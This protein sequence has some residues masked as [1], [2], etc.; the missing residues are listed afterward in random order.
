[1]LVQ[2]KLKQGTVRTV[3]WIPHSRKVRKGAL[4]IL[5]DGDESA[6]EVES[7]GAISEEAPNRGWKV[8]GLG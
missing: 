7:V 6:W 2:V 3:C 1:M 8:G 5:H 4:V